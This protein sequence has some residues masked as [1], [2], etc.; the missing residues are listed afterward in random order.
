[1]TDREFVML[2]AAPFTESPER[3]ALT[4]RQRRLI[5]DACWN[6]QDGYGVPGYEPLQGWDWSGIRDSTPEAFHLMAEAIRAIIG[7]AK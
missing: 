1:M 5:D 7:N 2:Y 3:K 4:P 6:L